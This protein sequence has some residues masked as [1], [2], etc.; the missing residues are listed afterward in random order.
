MAK[1]PR[2][3]TVELNLGAHR[4]PASVKSKKDSDWRIRAGTGGARS[5]TQTYQI[6]KSLVASM[7]YEVYS[8]MNMFSMTNLTRDRKINQRPRSQPG[9]TTSCIYRGITRKSQ[10]HP[11][12]ARKDKN[13]EITKRSRDHEVSRVRI[14]CGPRQY[15]RESALGISYTGTKG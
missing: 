3:Y 12:I 5:C 14:G 2:N 15:S 6:A 11:E 7:G 13:Q 8:R 4:S 10:D 1:R 9:I